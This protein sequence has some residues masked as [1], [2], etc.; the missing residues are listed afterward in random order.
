MK[1]KQ[2]ATTLETSA[3]HVG[4]TVNFPT[5]GK[6]VQLEQPAK[7]VGVAKDGLS[8]SHRSHYMIGEGGSG[9]A[10]ILTYKQTLQ[11]RRIVAEAIRYKG[12]DNDPRYKE[13]F[14]PEEFV[15]WSGVNLGNF[16]KVALAHPRQ[17]PGLKRLGDLA[18][19]LEA[20]QPVLILIGGCRDNRRIGGALYERQAELAGEQLVA[21]L[22]VPLDELRWAGNGF[23]GFG[24]GAARN[25][26]VELLNII[27][28]F[29]GGGAKGN[30][31]ALADAWVIRHQLLA[32]GYTRFRIDPVIY[33]PEVFKTAKQDRIRAN[34]HAFLVELAAVYNR[35]LLKMKIGPLW[36]DRTPP[37]GLVKLMNGVDEQGREYQ[38]DEVY[39]IEAECFRLSHFGPTGD[40]LESL[41][42][43]IVDELRWPFI[44]YSQNCAIKVL[45]VEELKHLNGLR[46]QNL[47]YASLAHQ[48]HEAE[49][50]QQGKH[51][52]QEWLRQRQLTLQDLSKLFLPELNS[53][54]ITQELRLYRQLPL[55]AMELARAKYSQ[56]KLATWQESLAQIVDQQTEWL[57]AALIC[58]IGQLLNQPEYRPNG[59]RWVLGHDPGARIEGLAYFLTD[60]K[61]MLKRKLIQAQSELDR[62]RVLIA[63]RPFILT[64]T[65]FR[66]FPR[67]RKRKWLDQTVLLLSLE[68]LM[69][70]LRAQ[71]ELISRVE[72]LVQNHSQAMLTWQTV[73]EQ[74]SQRVEEQI[75]LYASQRQ[76]RPIFEENILSPAEEEA[77]FA[78][79][80]DRAIT[81]SRQNLSFQWQAGQWVL[82]GH[83][84]E[85][86]LAFDAQELTTTDGLERFLEEYV[87][88]FWKDL[89]ELSLEAILEGRGED[90]VEVIAGMKRRCSPL[91]SVD[92]EQHQIQGGQQTVPLRREFILGTQHGK[93]GFFQEYTGPHGFAIV[94]T[95]EAGKHRLELL[96]TVFYVNPL[97]LTQSAEYKGAY[98]RLRA[99]GHNP[100]IFD[101]T[102]LGL[103]D[104]EVK[105]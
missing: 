54:R 94:T 10:T 99:T 16:L 92:H 20:L 51:L 4:E 55:A 58:W 67:L 102:E 46:H 97:A 6:T 68:L 1:S 96:S 73:L 56:L 18:T 71:L 69:L 3:I 66:L 21:D 63:K 100:H 17:F 62:Q 85:Q 90:H 52:A 64:R 34:T 30:T 79:R 59:V 77:L 88:S 5:N 31:A 76:H 41:L 78:A 27:Q 44:G 89:D 104:E 38:Q 61:H 9:I 12:F 82:Q 75:K 103:A 40:F 11:K 74:G 29:S 50:K 7:P 86:S 15:D 2:K 83:S 65:F 81:L 32:T 48:P 42:P 25:K 47:L 13:Q 37:Y 98:D 45:P 101:L 19:L 95:G 14:A 53:R 39:A 57:A 72:Q 80:I 23:G 33:L 8:G 28:V 91:I 105:E 60:L 35:H 87:I 84:G 43:N 49:L 93:Q 26:D 36:V 70:K 22:M 24:N